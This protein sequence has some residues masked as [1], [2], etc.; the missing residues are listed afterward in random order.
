MPK[1]GIAVGLFM[2]RQFV[3]WGLVGVIA[4]IL[5]PETAISSAVIGGGALF[6]VLYAAGWYL[7]IS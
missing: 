2:L 3:A 6:T 1:T 4:P 7:V 5:R